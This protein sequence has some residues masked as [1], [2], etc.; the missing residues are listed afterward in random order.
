MSSQRVQSPSIARCCSALAH[1]P[2]GW[3]RPRRPDRDFLRSLRDA[4]LPSTR[5]TV[6]VRTVRQVPAL[7]PKAMVVEGARGTQRIP[8]ALTAFVIEHPQAR[9]LVDPGLCSDAEHRALAQLPAVLRAAVRPP[10]DAVPTAHGLAELS[11]SAPIDFA[12]PTHLHWDHICGVLDMPGLPVQVHGTELAWA[13]AG[14]VAPV[15]GVRDALDDRPITAFQL[16]GPPVATFERSHDLFGDGAITL[17]DLP[18]HTPGSIGVLARTE[19]GWIL[20]AGD[21]AWH[22]AQIDEIRQKSS[23]PGGLADEDRDLCFQTLHRL[24]AARKHIRIVPTHDHVA[25]TALDRRFDQH[26]V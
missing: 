8:I 15:G 19:S 12:L 18:G 22:S 6:T 1:L 5:Q 7:V 21:A 11:D 24:H 2:I 9:I 26:P 16:D 17:V 14:S 20:L 4:G 23:Y 25:T 10:R 3:V 13:T